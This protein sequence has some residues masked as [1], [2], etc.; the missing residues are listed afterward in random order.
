MYT[1]AT[2]PKVVEAIEKGTFVRPSDDA[3]QA[4]AHDGARIAYE[5]FWHGGKG[6]DGSEH[7]FYPPDP[8][9]FTKDISVS[10]LFL[11]LLQET[12]F[13]IASVLRSRGHSV[14]LAH[15]PG[16]PVSNA[17]LSR[18]Y[19]YSHR[20]LVDSHGNPGCL[21]RVRSQANSPRVYPAIHLDSLPRRN[22]DHPY[23]VPEEMH[24]LFDDSCVQFTPRLSPAFPLQAETYRGNDPA[25][26][27]FPVERRKIVLDTMLACAAI[28]RSQDAHRDVKPQN[29]LARMTHRG[30]VGNLLDN[31]SRCP[32][33]SLFKDVYGTTPFLPHYWDGQGFK[34]FV[35]HRFQD[36]FAFGA[37][38]YDMSVRD[39]FE[40][41]DPFPG[42]VDLLVNFTSD[43]E[44]A[45][46][47]FNYSADFVNVVLS[48]LN[49]RRDKN[50]LDL[51]KCALVI[52]RSFGFKLVLLGGSPYVDF[53]DSYVPS[54]IVKNGLRT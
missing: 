5:E 10:G 2:P 48:M 25:L 34:N 28:H 50:L 11:P 42:I 45:K 26:E 35:D 14:Y 7:L 6:Q 17:A 46:T 27:L 23:L 37:I 21:Y 9:N 15:Q 31:E 47:Q 13:R 39:P 41:D 38:W 18:G 33:T 4:I 53:P 52:A 16:W 3:L 51:E 24:R 8:L 54:E 32:A 20:Y 1:F 22:I 49:C 40:R 29:I 43:L 30:L 36:I 19:D 44:Q 12:R